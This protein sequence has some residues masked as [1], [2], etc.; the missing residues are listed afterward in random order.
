MKFADATKCSNIFIWFFIAFINGFG[1]NENAILNDC[2]GLATIQI[3]VLLKNMHYCVIYIL[4]RIGFIITS[5]DTRHKQQVIQINTYDFI[6]QTILKLLHGFMKRLFLPQFVLL[7]S[8]QK[9]H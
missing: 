7:T 9:L 3:D 1:K 6:I 8:Q 4:R 5:G 2:W